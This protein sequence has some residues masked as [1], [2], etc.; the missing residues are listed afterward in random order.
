MRW[1]SSQ[2]VRRRTDSY[3]SSSWRMPPSGSRHDLPAEGAERPSGLGTSLIRALTV[4]SDDRVELTVDM[5]EGRKR[6]GAVEYGAPG[7][8]AVGGWLGSDHV[9]FVQLRH[10]SAPSRRSRHPSCRF[11]AHIIPASIPFT[12]PACFAASSAASL[13]MAPRST[14]PPV[15]RAV[16]LSS[17]SAPR[18]G[19][20]LATHLD[21]DLEAL[22]V[23]RALLVEHGVARQP[24]PERLRVLLQKALEVLLVVAAGGTQDQGINQ[25]DEHPRASARSRRPDTPQR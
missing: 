14:M 5:V 19:I 1:S 16:R 6:S 24:H 17:C 9:R 4:G 13:V 10:G 23:V 20:P 12:N 21:A 25:R 8:G 22:A 15:P 11:A 3:T 7:P 2:N 18:L